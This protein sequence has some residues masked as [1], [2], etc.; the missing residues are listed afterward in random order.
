MTPVHFVLVILQMGG[1]SWTIWLGWP[2]SMILLISTSQVWATSPQLIY[3]IFS[4]FAVL[5]LELKASHL[6]GRHS[7][8]WAIRPAFFYIGYFQDRVLRTI[9]PGWLG[10]LIFLISASWVAKIA[11]VSHGHLAIS[12]TMGDLVTSMSIYRC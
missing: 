5:G 3:I 12:I 6:L 10:T 2:W 1:V 8:T 9:C 11:E 4:F 7:T